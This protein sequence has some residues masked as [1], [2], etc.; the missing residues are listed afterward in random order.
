LVNLSLHH[1]SN[2]LDAWQYV[3]PLAPHI[4]IE[5]K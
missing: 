4:G 2:V 1:S 3:Q 5:V